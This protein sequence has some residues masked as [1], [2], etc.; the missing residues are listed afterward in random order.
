MLHDLWRA[1]PHGLRRRLFETVVLART[2]SA[3]PAPSVP[4][5]APVTVAGVLKAPTGLGEA[6]RGTIL[7]LKAAGRDVRAIDLTGPFRQEV[8]VSAPEVPAATPGAGVLIVFA[9][10]PMSSYALTKI[11]SSLIAGKFRVCSWVWEY[12]TVPARWKA[13][14]APYHRL[15]APTRLVERAVFLTTGQTAAALPYHV[16]VGDVAPEVPHRPGHFRIGFVGDMVAAAGRKNPAAVIEAVGRAFGGRPDVTLVLVLRGASDDQP[17]VAELRQRATTLGVN[18]EID[19]RLLDTP[20]HWAR[21]KSLDAFCSLHRAEGFGL[22]IAEAM[23]AGLP[24]VATL[25]PAVSDYLDEAS[26]YPVPFRPVK[27]APLVD[28][29]DPGFWA[30][31]DIAVA[32]AALVAIRDNRGE[33]QRRGMAAAARIAQLY[34]AAAVAAAVDAIVAP[35]RT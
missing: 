21:L 32:A 25:C 26:G 23:A 29:P 15:A 12:A 19:A 6:A 20:A 24:T 5:D 27:A 34:G 14:V 30:E 2:P 13:H 3:G 35:A 31:P 22:T 9:N 28:D 1:L 4:A 11:D 18:L 33:A 8:V 17:I 7:A 10:P 16:A